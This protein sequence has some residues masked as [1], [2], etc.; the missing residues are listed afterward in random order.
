MFL[1][2]AKGPTDGWLNLT[3]ILKSKAS[4]EVTALSLCTKCYNVLGVKTPLQKNI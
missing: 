3:N 2:T 4:V 1:C